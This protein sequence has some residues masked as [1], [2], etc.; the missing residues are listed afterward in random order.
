MKF[1][2]IWL[3]VLLFL[4]QLLYLLNTIRDLNIS[5]LAYV[6]MVFFAFTILSY[7]GYEK[8]WDT[9]LGK[10]IMIFTFI[11]LTVGTFF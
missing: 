4:V 5:S 1:T 3:I 6:M 7:F 8:V 2:F 9:T 10:I 11:T